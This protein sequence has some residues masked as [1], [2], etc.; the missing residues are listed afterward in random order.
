MQKK[1]GKSK[2]NG[3]SSAM[4]VTLQPDAAGVDIGAEE[5][6]VAVPP[7][8]DENPVRSF[9]T[10]T[11]D[12]NEMADWLTQCRIRTKTRKVKNRAA[13]AL[14]PG[15]S[16]LHHAKNFFGEFFRRMKFRMGTPQAITATAH[17]LARIIYHMLRTKEAYSESVLVKCQELAN[18]RAEARL[19]RRA[20]QM[21]FALT[22]QTPPEGVVL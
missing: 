3:K 22:P 11:R 5:I 20:A 18:K 15:A 8:R 2:G 7:D 14:R 21:G 4:L 16:C 10:F 19:R 13:I 17:K 6:Y 9:S 12:L 1:K